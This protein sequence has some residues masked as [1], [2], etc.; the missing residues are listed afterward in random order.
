MS[1]T[2][3]RSVDAA[4]CEAGA[5]KNF[6]IKT[7]VNAIALWVAALVEPGITLAQGSKST[8]S[9]LLTIVLVAV[10][11]GIINAIIKPIATFFSFPLI[12]LTV[13]LF[14]FIVNALML[15]LLSWSSGK[16]GLAFHVDHF[17]WSAVLGALVVSFVAILLNILLP[18][19]HKVR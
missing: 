2:L 12:V 14:T 10:L 15:Q 11:F 9:K 16:L 13:G 5:M 3:L 1:I 17:F 7:G 6:A 18:D 8:S 19:D 4:L